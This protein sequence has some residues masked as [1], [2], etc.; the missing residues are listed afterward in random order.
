[1]LYVHLYNAKP[2]ILKVRFLEGT[3]DLARERAARAIASRTA[4]TTGIRHP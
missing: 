2:S 1:V 4:A 3:H